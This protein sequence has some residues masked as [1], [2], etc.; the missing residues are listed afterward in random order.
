LKSA[1]DGATDVTL[2]IPYVGDIH[3]KLRLRQRGE[4]MKAL[5]QRVWRRL[6]SRDK[7]G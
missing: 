1:D 7:N 6:L 2:K 5:A 3:F 4:R